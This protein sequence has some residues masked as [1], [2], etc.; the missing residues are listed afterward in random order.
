MALMNNK[1]NFRSYDP[2]Q[3]MLLPPSL[4]DWLPEGHLAYF[5]RETVEELDLSAILDT[6][7]SSRGGFPAYHPV[8]MTQL[9]AYGYCVGVRSSR[10]IERATHEVVPFRVLAANQ[11]PDHDTI[12]EFRRRH[13]DALANLFIQILDMCREEGMAKL[14]RVAIDGSKVRANA[15]KHKALSY[16]RMP[17]ALAPDVGPARRA[18]KKKDAELKKIVRDMFDEAERIDAEEDALYGKGNRGDELPE[19]LRHAKTRRKKIREAIKNLKAR[20]KAQ[21]DAKRAEIAE[22]EKAREDEGKPRRGRKPKEPSDE[23]DEK[24]QSPQ[25]RTLSGADP[26]GNFTDPESRIMK[27]GSTGSFEQ[28]YPEGPHLRRIGPAGNAQVAVDADTQVI[29][30]ADVTQQA[31]DPKSR[32][33]RGKKQLVPMVE[34]VKRNTG[35]APAKV[36]ADSGYYSEANVAEMQDESIDA[37]IAT[38][39]MKHGEIITAPRGRIPESAT[40]KDRMRRKLRTQKGRATY[41]RR[42]SSVEPVIGQVK[43]VQGFRQFLRRGLHAAQCEWRFGCAMHNLLKLFRRMR[44]AFA[45]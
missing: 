21:A 2:D 38:G 11:H 36:L 33:L 41:A 22:K 15:S 19:E 3:S 40:T 13:A 42:K 26:P 35:S 5:V 29:V 20:K 23:P 9:L 31:N 32:A 27:M 6:Y 39:K 14:G 37:Y 10:K 28:C 30:A 4:H 1:R 16:G 43:D 18:G 12:S 8:M 34:Q 25:V 44:P 17:G 7:D 24:M 45:W